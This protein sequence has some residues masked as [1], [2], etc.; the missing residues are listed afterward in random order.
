M[1]RDTVL[2]CC[3]VIC[4]VLFYRMYILNQ[5]INNLEERT[6]VIDNF[7]QSIFQFITQKEEARLKQEHEQENMTKNQTV[8]EVVYSNNQPLNSNSLTPIVE[9]E[10]ETD[11]HQYNI[12]NTNSGEKISETFESKEILSEMVDQLKE[13]VIQI[14]N[15]NLENELDQIQELKQELKQELSTQDNLFNLLSSTDLTSNNQDVKVLDIH[16]ENKQELSSKKKEEELLKMSLS[17]IKALAKIK[18]ISVMKS[19]KPKKKELL[20]QEILAV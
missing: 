2:I 14:N 7:S 18:N 12:N 4:C 19:N 10:T 11:D 13:S 5:K 16:I 6:S 8:N 20:I 1:I 9:E 3:I 17:E 15:E